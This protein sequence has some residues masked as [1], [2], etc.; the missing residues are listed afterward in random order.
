MTVYSRPQVRFL[1]PPPYVFMSSI[2]RFALN[3]V[4][5]TVPEPDKKE[6]VV[7]KVYD[8]KAVPP[9]RELY[10]SWVSP[11]RTY[12]PRSKEFYKKIASIILVVGGFLVLLGLPLLA[13][14]FVSVAVLFYVLTNVPPDKVK[15]EIDNYG[16]IYLG[17]HY[18][19][20]E[21][22]YFFFT[23][24]SGFTILNVD[25]SD[26]YPGR[27]IMLLDGVSADSVKDVLSK[28]LPMKETPPET[29]F[30]KAFKRISSKVSL[31]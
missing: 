17:N 21:F 29:V 4:F 8:R 31:E 25:T 22:K 9:N 26:P 10:L 18:F 20:E 24:D 14:V 5:P 15:H 16:I 7:S 23:E 1:Y 11:M 13:A 30:D 12:R 2:I 3:S 6:A 27:M 28:H 19:W